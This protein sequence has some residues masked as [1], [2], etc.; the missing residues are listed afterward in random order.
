M[1]PEAATTSGSDYFGGPR[2]PRRV[3]QVFEPPIGGVP[4]YVLALSAGLVE[5]GWS[6][7]V[8]H[9]VGDELRDAV[10]DAGANSIA[11]ELSHGPHPSDARVSGAIARLLR[12][13]NAD[14]VHSHSTKAGL[15]AGVA[16][17]KAGVPSVYTPHG[18]AFQRRDIGPLSRSGYTGL[19]RGLARWCH[20][21]V[22]V[23]SNEERT[24]ALQRSVAS[25]ER[26]HVV[27]TGLRDRRVPDRTSARRVLGLSADELVAVWV[28]RWAP[29]KRP[30]DLA[31]LARRLAGTARIVALGQGLADSPEGAAFLAEG[32]VIPPE[33]I[34]PGIA[35]AAADL[36]VQTSAWEG[37]S[38]AVLEAMSAGLP[39]VAY[40]VGGLPEQVGRR[41]R[42]CPG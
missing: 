7:D 9:P 22:V 26:L 16:A 34:N 2:A 15:L 6:V 39:V 4:A 3:V 12:Y 5:R 24:E 13:R 28:G 11:L 40:A 21:S 32:G 38:I 23:V 1:T 33:T 35:Y 14:V 25:P 19:E 30:A 17:R 10:L 36:F 18:W 41:R 31:P 8:I 27:H 20:G 29:Q 37:L 42:R